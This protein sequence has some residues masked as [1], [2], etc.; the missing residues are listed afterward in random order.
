MPSACL[1]SSPRATSSS[2]SRCVR[3]R[4]SYFSVRDYLKAVSLLFRHDL[5]G[6]MTTWQVGDVI[7]ITR[8]DVGDGWWE[9]E[10]DGVY[11]LF[12]EKYVLLVCC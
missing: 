9:G 7:R 4:E 6:I 11:G 5:I 8:R 1:H 2:T 12:P 10:L 3:K